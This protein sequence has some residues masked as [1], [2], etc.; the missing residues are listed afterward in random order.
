MNFNTTDQVLVNDEV[1]VDEDGVETGI[2]GDLFGEVADTE[3]GG[4]ETGSVR[5]IEAHEDSAEE[6]CEKKR[7][8]PDLGMPT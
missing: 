3:A 7:I 6:D 5:R 4:V 2:E 1:G 8:A